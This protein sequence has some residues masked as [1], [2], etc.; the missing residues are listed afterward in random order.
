MN[1]Q[2]SIYKPQEEESLHSSEEKECSL[3]EFLKLKFM[4]R[5]C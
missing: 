4:Y 2:F 3:S 5:P 1:L